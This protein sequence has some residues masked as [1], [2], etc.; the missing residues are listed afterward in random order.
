MQYY[1]CLVSNLLMC[2]QHIL[3]YGLSYVAIATT[4]SA[5]A[6]TMKMS[7]MGAALVAI[8]LSIGLLL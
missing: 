5:A 4:G 6:G 8:S 7:V 1:I 2:E 3:T